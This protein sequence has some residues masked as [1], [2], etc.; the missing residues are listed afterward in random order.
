MRRVCWQLCAALAVLLAAAGPLTAELGEWGDAPEGA[1][2]YPFLSPPVG[3][4]FPTCL[5]VTIAPFLY[6]GPLCWAHFP[7][8]V[9]A[10]DFEYEGNAGNCPNFPPYDADE[11]FIVDAGLLYPDPYTIDA[12]LNVV[13]C[14]LGVGTPLGQTCTYAQWGVDIDI[15]VVN[16]MPCTGY[17][18]VLMDWDQSGYWGDTPNCP[19][20]GPAPEHVLVNLPVPLGF[21][22]PLSSLGPGGFLIGPNDQYVWSRFT[23]SESPVSYPWD[24]SGSFEDGETED[25]LLEILLNTP[26]ESESWGTIKG[27]YR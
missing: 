1:V 10:F 4:Q 11:C 20:V 16:A 21:S 22:G 8:Q 12:Q 19:G 23:I 24:G 7:G 6:H 15:Q 9:P 14:P 27:L 26:V 18:N 2:A 5:N 3:G 13:P 17:V 25:Y